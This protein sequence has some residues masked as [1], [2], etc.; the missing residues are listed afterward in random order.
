MKYKRTEFERQQ[1]EFSR[2]EQELR[3]AGYLFGDESRRVTSRIARMTPR[4][5]VEALQKLN[6]DLK[7]S[8]ST[9]KLLAPTTRGAA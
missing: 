7:A 9:I 4:E 6:R 5:V 2:G 8:G 1:E 3:K